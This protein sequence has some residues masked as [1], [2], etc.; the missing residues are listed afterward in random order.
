MIRKLGVHGYR[1][2]LAPAPKSQSVVLSRVQTSTNQVQPGLWSADASSSLKEGGGCSQS[3]S[4]LKWRVWTFR[5]RKGGSV[6]RHSS[7]CSIPRPELR[8]PVSCWPGSPLLLHR[9]GGR[10][11]PISALGA[12]TPPLLLL[13]LLFSLQ[14]LCPRW[15]RGLGCYGVV[16]RG[17]GSNIYFIFCFWQ[18]L[19][20]F[21]CWEGP[22]RS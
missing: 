7:F 18:Q 21:C 3:H 1:A 12:A 8:G 13:L 20:R 6:P 17:G 14:R 2:T 15:F 5:D 19:N 9:I 4:T 22:Q 10:Q 16:L 11:L